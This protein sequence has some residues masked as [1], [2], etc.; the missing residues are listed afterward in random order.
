M[1]DLVFQ[2]LN[3]TRFG[4]SCQTVYWYDCSNSFYAKLS[5][6]ARHWCV[7]DL[8]RSPP[9]SLQKLI[10]LMG[11]N[12]EYRTV[13]FVEI[14]I[15]KLISKLQIELYILHWSDRNHYFWYMK[16]HGHTC[17]SLVRYPG[18]FNFIS[19]LFKGHNIQINFNSKNL[20]KNWYILS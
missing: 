17:L 3:E 6:G 1:V 2:K 9:R 11:K 13:Y 7:N 10:V 5:N 12:M 15:L 8:T 18:K 16:W 19:Y 4:R 14:A 20:Q